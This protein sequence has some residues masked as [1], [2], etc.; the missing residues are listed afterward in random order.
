MAVV[1]IDPDKMCSWIPA[2]RIGPHGSAQWSSGRQGS[3]ENDVGRDGLERQEH[4]PEQVV[5]QS[6]DPSRRCS[7]PVAGWS[8]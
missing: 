7:C 3:A 6:R 1:A 4:V 5:S 2:M 8:S